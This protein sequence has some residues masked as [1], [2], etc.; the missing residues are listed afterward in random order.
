MARSR[1]L[2]AVLTALL[3]L[4]VPNAVG[5]HP[6][7]SPDCDGDNKAVLGDRADWAAVELVGWVL[8][9]DCLLDSGDRDQPSL[10]V[11]TTAAYGDQSTIVIGGTAA[12]PASKL[13]EV[14]IEMRLDG[15]DRLET[16]REVVE[17]AD[18]Q[19]GRGTSPIA[20]PTVITESGTGDASIPVTLRV[21]IYAVSFES[22]WE[23]SDVRLTHEDGDDCF[24]SVRAGEREVFVV[25]ANEDCPSGKMT[26][27]VDASDFRRNEAD[28]TV[29]IEPDLD[30]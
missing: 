23:Y 3:L 6:S 20:A 25:H 8:R 9:T 24:R 28:W 29:N 5:A 27:K 26:L 10:P 12:V 11:G 15:G 7:S 17:W 30:D 2:I 16:M 4:A 19:L 21:G 18:E 14:R 13:S 22:S 1:V